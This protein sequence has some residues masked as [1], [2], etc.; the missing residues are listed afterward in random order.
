MIKFRNLIVHQY[1]EIDPEIVFNIAK[2][3]LDSFRTFRDEID[4]V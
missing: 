3:Q 1:E 4:K 2:N